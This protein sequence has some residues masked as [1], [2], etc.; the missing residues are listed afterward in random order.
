MR[1][2]FLCLMILLFGGA[3]TVFA[4][5][6]PCTI[7]PMID[8]TRAL[9]LGTAAYDSEELVD[10]TVYLLDAL[11]QIDAA[12]VAC[13]GEAAF[14][15]VETPEPTAAP[16]VIAGEVVVIESDVVL[17]VPFVDVRQE[18]SVYIPQGFETRADTF[19][20]SSG[21]EARTLTLNPSG[22]STLPNDTP[23]YTVLL[24]DPIAIARWAGIIDEE[25]LAANFTGIGS[26]EA[27]LSSLNVPPE[28]TVT[29][30]LIYRI[31]L[32][33]YEGVALRFAVQFAGDSTALEAVMYFVD[34]GDG[35][36]A[37]FTSIAPT[38]ELDAQ[39]P[40]LN[41]IAL[42]LKTR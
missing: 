26:F 14:A 4:Q 30:S 21:G 40:T 5:S 18:I 23:P 12:I 39:I 35:V 6:D 8:I 24:G 41:A 25:A 28:V 16:P 1:K 11:N 13:G 3:V 31:N 7:D 9:R 22:G 34:L 2:F 42:S 32:A 19:G 37:A 27:A 29:D 33:G 38:G 36:Y 10:A 17:T 20:S 15:P